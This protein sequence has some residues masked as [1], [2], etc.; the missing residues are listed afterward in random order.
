MLKLQNNYNYNHKT[1]KGAEL[2]NKSLGVT[3]ISDIH[4][5]V[6]VLICQMPCHV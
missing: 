1:T 3:D 4:K 6:K 2:K 5:Y